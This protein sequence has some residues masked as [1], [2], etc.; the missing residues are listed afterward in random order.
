MSAALLRWAG[1][2]C[3]AAAIVAGGYARVDFSSVSA[4]LG[5]S[6]AVFTGLAGL[7]QHPPWAQPQPPA[8]PAA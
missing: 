8:P 3:M 7:C 1:F 5:A 4:I 6:V 2:G